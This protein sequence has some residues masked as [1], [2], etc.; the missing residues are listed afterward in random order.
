MTGVMMAQDFRVSPAKNAFFERIREKYRSL[1]A[2][3]AAWGTR[4]ATWP[5]LVSLPMPLPG[6][7]F[8]ADA[9]AFVLDWLR[10]Y[11]KAARNAVKSLAPKRLYFSAAFAGMEQPT[12][13]WDAASEFADVLLADVHVRDAEVLRPLQSERAPE[14][15]LL[16]GAF[17]FGCVDRGMFAAGPVRLPDQPARAEALRTFIRG[18]ITNPLVVGAHWF[19]YRDQPLIGR[20][21]GEAFEIGLVDVCD[22]PYRE[23]VAAAREIGEGMYS[24]IP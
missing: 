23:V 24:A 3:N 7:G 9:E 10:R 6:A 20:E 11:F 1:D 8:V 13:A 17:T 15:P 16:I 19:Q 14:R 21:D 22:R 5:E 2:I 12:A 18:A 4:L